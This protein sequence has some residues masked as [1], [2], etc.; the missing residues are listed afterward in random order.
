VR[1]TAG[2]AQSPSGQSAAFDVTAAQTDTDS[3]GMP[4]AWESANGLNPAVNDAT[5]DFDK[6][7]WTNRMEYLA[8]TNPRSAASLLTISSA[9]AQ[10]PSQVSLSWP[11]TAN[12]IYRVRYSTGLSSWAYVP[13]QIYFP[14][15]AGTQTATFP[16]P[17][18][19]GTR[20]FYQVELLT[21]P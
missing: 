13:G 5:G 10:L 15:A 18:G 1:I 3:D 8:G 16:P 12:R 4:D 6:D 9:A 21:P 17:A 7:G 20:A 2:G 14:V 11:A 19:A